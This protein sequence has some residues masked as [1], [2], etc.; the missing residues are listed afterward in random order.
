MLSIKLMMTIGLIIGLA[1]DKITKIIPLF[2]ILWV[3]YPSWFVSYVI[4][5]FF[6]L[7]PDAILWKLG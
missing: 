3:E 7:W 1:Y 4:L 2:V 6:Q 5:I